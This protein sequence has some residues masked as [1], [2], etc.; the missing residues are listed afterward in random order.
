MDG[1]IG[2][3]SISSPPRRNHMAHLQPDG[4]ELP[5]GFKTDVTIVE[6]TSVV[7]DIQEL[8]RVFS[9]VIYASTDANLHAHLFFLYSVKEVSQ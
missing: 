9:S 2:V 5:A 4:R 7:H 6:I 8:S 1:D 3:F